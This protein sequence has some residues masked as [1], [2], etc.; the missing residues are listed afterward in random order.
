MKIRIVAL[1]TALVVLAV[2]PAF[3]AGQQEGGEGPIKLGGVWPLGDI[4]GDQGSKAA[5]LAVEEINDAGG[6]LGR[7]LELIVIDSELKPE[8][9][10]SALERLAT[11]ENVD[12]F[13]GGM[14]SNVHL[15][16]IPTLKKY[17]KIAMWT[18][19]ASVRAE[20][21]VGPDA[22]W[23][24]HLHPWDYTQGESYVEGWNAIAEEYPEVDTDR[25]FIAYEDGPFGTS[26]FEASKELYG[27]L[28][29]IE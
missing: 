20:E 16:Q 11:V 9:G 12:M 13:V 24:F 26:S 6:V 10:A 1:V 2:A 25:W 23:Y 14:A 8:K 21:A 29:E 18:G 28:G 22:E 5:Q 7:P 4:T 19:A 15:A 27:E 3:S 17:E